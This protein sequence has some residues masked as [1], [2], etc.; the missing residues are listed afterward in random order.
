VITEVHVVIFLV[1]LFL[2]CLLGFP[3]M[4]RALKRLGLIDKS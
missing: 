2:F 3:L 1:G 4:G